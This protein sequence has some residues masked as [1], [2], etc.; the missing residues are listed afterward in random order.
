M[1]ITQGEDDAEEGI[2]LPLRP[3][4][5]GNVQADIGI[6]AVVGRLTVKEASPG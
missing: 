5:T 6:M 4:F 3:V 1:I 2:S